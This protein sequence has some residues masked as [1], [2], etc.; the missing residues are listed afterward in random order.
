MWERFSYED[1]DFVPCVSP[2]TGNIVYVRYQV[3]KDLEAKGWRTT[4]EAYRT[5]IAG[6]D[7]SCGD[8]SLA[9]HPYYYDPFVSVNVDGRPLVYVRR[10][11][12]PH[13]NGHPMLLAAFR[14]ESKSVLDFIG[15][16]NF[17]HIL[18]EYPHVRV[19]RK[20][21]FSQ[22][23]RSTVLSK[24]IASKSTDTW[25]RVAWTVQTISKDNP[26]ELY[27]FKYYNDA[28]DFERSSAENGYD[29]YG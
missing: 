27:F 8:K 26:P 22:E 3:L 6:S 13:I 29:L 21:K 18:D 11:V 20:K 9:D 16:L 7:C 28:K 4:S 17:S 24:L 23:Q 1:N 25:C 5:S 14:A 10:T 19:I 15:H 12:N 2:W